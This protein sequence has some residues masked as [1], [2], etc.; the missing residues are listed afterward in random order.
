MIDDEKFRKA[1]EGRHTPRDGVS[2]V[3]FY[4]LKDSVWLRDYQDR[5]KRDL[6]HRLSDY[7]GL[8]RPQATA[9][10][11]ATI[12]GLEASKDPAG[13]I[14]TANMKSRTH[15][16][17]EA[18]RPFLVDEF[19]Q[20][21]RSAPTIRVRFGDC[22]PQDVNPHDK[23]RRP[24][25]RSFEVR[26]DGLAVLMGWPIGRNGRPFASDLHDLRIALQKFGVV[27]KYHLEEGN[28]DNDV[29]MV[30]AALEYPMWMRLSEQE[31]GSIRVI[32]EQFQEEAR[33]LLEHK[34]FDADL[35]PKDMWVVKYRRT[36]LEEVVFAK[37]VTE[38]TA[39]EVRSLYGMGG[40]RS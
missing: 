14:V 17:G 33:E 13:E 6:T 2:L 11:H 19:L 30:I 10:V 16:T 22:V 24:W 3:A 25:E 8:V 7:P 20:F 35:P 27:H 1:Y 31:R 4:G 28:I 36:T 40:S 5:L 37:R 32:L 9:W 18:V 38:L 12:S 23:H 39:D 21:V 29:F 34:P 15:N 26:E